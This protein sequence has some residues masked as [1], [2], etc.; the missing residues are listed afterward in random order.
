V[1]VFNNVTYLTGGSCAP[2]TPGAPC[3][4][5]PTEDGVPI[6]IQGSIAGSISFTNTLQLW[7]AD[8]TAVMPIYR[9]GTL[10]V[11]GLAGL[12]YLELSETFNLTGSLAGLTGSLYAGQSGTVTDEF[13]T[14]NQF[15]GAVLG[16]RAH[17]AWGP[18]SLE[19]TGRVALGVS[20]EILDVSGFY[21]DVN[22]PFAA[23]S[24]P[25]GIFAMPANEGRFTSNEFA[26]V[27]EAQVKVGY[28]LTPWIRVTAG[29]DFLYD[30]NVIRP[31][32][33]INRAIPKGQT[34]QQDGTSP[35]TT[36]PDRLFKTTDFYAQGLNAGLSVRF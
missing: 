25:Y 13:D 21:Q 27:P 2:Q 1:P 10:E 29:Y 3:S 5:G 19:L 32:D 7:G 14:R 16:L 36:S 18:L 24:G 4:I 8:A 17:D 22:A 9:A 28:D 35:S 23:K 12:S 34:F 6:G 33:Q 20:H 11:S 26:A 15:F 31:T 30:S